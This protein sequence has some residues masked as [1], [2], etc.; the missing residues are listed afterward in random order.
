MTP[1]T[2]LE[3]SLPKKMPSIGSLP[4][5]GRRCLLKKIRIKRDEARRIAA[6][7]AK[8]PSLLARPAGMAV[9]DSECARV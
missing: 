9:P 4:N 8:P 3:N 1:C 6:N 7:I 2:T 5:P